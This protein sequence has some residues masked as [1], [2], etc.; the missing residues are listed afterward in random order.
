V[1]VFPVKVPMELAQ[2]ANS[3]EHTFNLTEDELTGAAGTICEVHASTVTAAMNKP[4]NLT[5]IMSSLLITKNLI[6]R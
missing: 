3:P 4:L 1:I 5:K 2:S 6:G